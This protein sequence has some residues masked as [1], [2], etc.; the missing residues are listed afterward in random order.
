MFKYINAMPAVDC[1]ITLF[2]KLN[3]RFATTQ[4]KM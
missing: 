3:D 4:I 1:Y 2:S